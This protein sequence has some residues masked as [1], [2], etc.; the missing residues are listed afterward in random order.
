MKIDR[1]QQPKEQ[2]R[3]DYVRRSLSLKTQGSASSSGSSKS[4]KGSSSRK[5]TKREAETFTG[6]VNLFGGE[7]LGIFKDPT[8]LKESPDMLKTWSHLEKHE[9]QLQVTHPPANYFE[10]LALWTE[11]NKVW[12]FP[13]DNERGLD[14]EAN[15][16]FS[17]HIFLEQYLEPWCPDKGPIRH[18]MELVCVGLS[19]N[20]HITA[21]EKK[22]HILW[23]K[24]YFESKKDLLKDLMN[25]E[26]M[27]Q[28]AKEKGSQQKQVEA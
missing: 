25:K 14:E 21:K 13:I 23:Y 20:Y 19:K 24:D 22:E 6:S 27:N 11:Q 1:R 28:I 10:K 12:K 2:T 9:L 5:P 16:D 15:V 18:F 7:A 26:K 8:Q 3:G 4:N 17:E